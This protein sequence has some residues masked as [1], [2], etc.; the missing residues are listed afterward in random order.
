M[1]QGKELR[2][3][4]SNAVSFKSSRITDKGSV[5]FPLAFENKIIPFRPWEI[6]FLD[7]YSRGMDPVKVCMDMGLEQGKAE[8]LLMRPR[9]R[10][11]LADVARQYAAREG[12][13]PERWFSEGTK[14]WNGEKEVSR[15]QLDVWKEMGGRVA[16]RVEKG[17]DTSKPIININIGA[18]NDA[19]KRQDIIDAQVQR[20][21]ANG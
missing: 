9:A 7:A 17:S 5:F 1:E 8:R 20:D 19:L 4:L 2:T 21:P 12:W 13:T 3:S 6:R 14:V 18:M 15:E 10:A 11:Y 16:P